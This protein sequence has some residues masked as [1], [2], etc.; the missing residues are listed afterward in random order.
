MERARHIIY[1]YES[2]ERHT[3]THRKR[4]K[5][6]ERER[7]EKTDLFGPCFFL[8]VCPPNDSDHIPSTS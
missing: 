5:E 4:K 6:R 1:I 3:H 8:S 7:V 2:I